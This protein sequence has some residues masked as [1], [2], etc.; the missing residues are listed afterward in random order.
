M[1]NM[2]KI[3]VI[4]AIVYSFFQVAFASNP[5]PEFVLSDLLKKA[6][7][8]ENLSFMR[9]SALID[10]NKWAEAE[11]LLFSIPSESEYNVEMMKIFNIVLGLSKAQ[12]SVRNMSDEQEATLNEIALYSTTRAKYQA[13]AILEVK[14]D[15]VFYRP[16]EEWQKIGSKVVKNQNSSNTNDLFSIVP[17]PSDNYILLSFDKEFNTN[18]TSTVSIFDLQGRMVLSKLVIAN[19]NNLQIDISTYKSGIY[20]VKVSNSTQ[21]GGKKIVIQH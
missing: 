4:L 20:F 17:N 13:Q 12:M 19:D 21:I 3:I 16:I 1:Y 10:E 7:Y 15:M 9:L 5:S 6:S 8:K 2:K 18:E 11:K 14:N